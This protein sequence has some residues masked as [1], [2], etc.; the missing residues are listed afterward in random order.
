M[1]PTWRRMMPIK[2]K[3]WIVFAALLVCLILSL[4]YSAPFMIN[5]MIATASPPYQP[6]I[7]PQPIVDEDPAL[8]AQ[9]L[10]KV[11]DLD[12]KHGANS[13][14]TFDDTVRSRL[15]HRQFQDLDEFAAEL[16]DTKSTLPG[17]RWRLTRV[18]AQLSEPAA[19]TDTPDE[20]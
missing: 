7:A 13:Y 3:Q 18:Y 1:I 15:R 10:S 4:A 11:L 5:A 6:V 9:P 20:D 16:R 2:R 14:K 12:F 19:G 8:A 17:G